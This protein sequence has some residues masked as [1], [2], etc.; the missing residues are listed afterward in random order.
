MAKE[1]DV[2]S[3]HQDSPPDDSRIVSIHARAFDVCQIIY[4]EAALSSQI[5]DRF[6]ENGASELAV[7]YYPQC[8]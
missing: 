7:I 6:Y 8:G 3:G 1:N 2:V 4:G 5:L